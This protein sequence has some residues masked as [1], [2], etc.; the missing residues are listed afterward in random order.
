[1]E[2][3][4]I[5]T[6]DIDSLL[7][8]MEKIDKVDNIMIKDI[9][10]DYTSPIVLHTGR[11]RH[12]SSI[13]S[14]LQFI[15]EF[16]PDRIIINSDNEIIIRYEN[17][18]LMVGYRLFSIESNDDLV[19][20]K[21]D[22][23]YPYDSMVFRILEPRTELR[24]LKTISISE[25]GGVNYNRFFP[26][27]CNSIT[28]LLQLK[29]RHIQDQTIIRSFN[30]LKRHS[31]G[32]IDNLR[33]L[34]RTSKK[35]LSEETKERLRILRSQLIQANGNY[36]LENPDPFSELSQKTLR[37]NQT[38]ISLLLFMIDNM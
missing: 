26:S 13:S 1:M 6:K 2:K 25:F 19:G 10:C 17:S 27:I 8:T 36:V 31:P 4:D 20:L 35:E 33:E 3:P 9:I 12:F 15:Q 29:P 37:E 23:I 30:T 32:L 34:F 5:Y 16:Y 21:A 11:H 18:Y 24:G 7:G 14:I 38:V 22:T 28:Q